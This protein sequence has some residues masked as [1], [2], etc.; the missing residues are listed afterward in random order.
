V[1]NGKPS[2]AIEGHGGVAHTQIIAGVCQLPTTDAVEITTGVE[3]VQS[4]PKNA[5]SDP[6]FQPDAVRYEW[7]PEMS[8]SGRDPD[9]EDPLP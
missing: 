6:V 1:S 7:R 3:R 9:R 4:V 2:T 5:V 8:C